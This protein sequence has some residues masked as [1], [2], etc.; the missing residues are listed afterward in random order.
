MLQL[1]YGNK[2]LPDYFCLLGSHVLFK[3]STS[4]Y[5]GVFFDCGLRWSTQT[6][7]VKRRCLR[8]NYLIE[9][10]SGCVI[11]SASVLYASAI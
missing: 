9:I 5:L 8:K 1:D 3:A 2:N 4:K 7:Y 6:K 11:R 10:S